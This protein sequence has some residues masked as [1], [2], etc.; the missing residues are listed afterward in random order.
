MTPSSTT[1]MR[2]KL[3]P[4]EA[5]EALDELEYHPHHVHAPG[6]RTTT[7]TSGV[8]AATAA[9]AAAAAASGGGGA[10]SPPPP[11]AVVG[12]DG[13]NRIASPAGGD[14]GIEA[15]GG[16]TGTPEGQPESGRSSSEKGGRKDRVATGGK[17]AS[18][19]EGGEGTMIQRM[20]KTFRPDPL[21]A[22]TGDRSTLRFK[23]KRQEGLTT[24]R[25]RQQRTI[26]DAAQISPMLQVRV[27]R[28]NGGGRRGSPRC[29]RQTMQLGL[30]L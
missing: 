16:A 1:E 22:Y 23:P 5:A 17:G 28:R 24:L 26:F 20:N 25:P 12:A 29:A 6:A 14:G 2:T 21:G 27:R 30:L 19:G 11:E 7:T 10:S 15:G 18:A 13:D 8:T 9:A 3:F 4:D